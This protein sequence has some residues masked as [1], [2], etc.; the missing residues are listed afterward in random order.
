MSRSTFL[1]LLALSVNA[2]KRS[3]ELVRD[4]MIS[5]NLKIVEKG[6]KDYQTEADRLAQQCIMASI[7]KSFNKVNIRGEEDLDVDYN[8]IDDR[9]ICTSKDED[10]LKENCPKNLLEL[11]EEDIHIWVDPLDATREFTTGEYEAVTILVGMAYNERPIAG[12]ICQPFFNEGKTSRTLWSIVGGKTVGLNPLPRTKEKDSELILTQTKS[13]QSEITNLCKEAIAP[14]KTLSMGGAGNKGLSVLEGKAD[15]YVH[16]CIGTKRWDTCAIEAFTMALGGKMTD[17]EGKLYSYSTK[18]DNA[19]NL[20]GVLFC[21]D[22]K[23][24]EKCME[25]IPN[26]I[27][28]YLKN[29]CERKT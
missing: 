8:K 13:H 19:H 27:T 23:I 16:A 20:G 1:N 14:T 21:R 29:K 22:E 2:V 4:V 9:L 11:N 28:N 10:I 26:T 17:L 25:R 12:I 24:W 6:I 18:I 7:L 15:V 5:G 3:S